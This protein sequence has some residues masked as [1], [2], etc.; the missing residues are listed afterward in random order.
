MWTVGYG[1]TRWADGSHVSGGNASVSE[2][3]A[4]ALMEGE[5]DPIVDAI[6]DLAPV[7]IATPN[8]VAACASLAYNIGLS[9]F[10]GSTVLHLWQEENTTLAAQH[11]LDWRFDHDPVTRQLVQVRGLKNRRMKEQSVFLGGAP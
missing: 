7:G 10:R 2:P 9:A 8:Q 6:T 1:S 3:A 4:R 11:F 5:L